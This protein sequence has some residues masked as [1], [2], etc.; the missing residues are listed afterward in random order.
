M[1]KLCFRDLDLSYLPYTGFEAARILVLAFN[2]ACIPDLVIEIVYCSM[3]SW[4][5]V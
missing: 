1:F 3:A 4:M 5:A 2:V